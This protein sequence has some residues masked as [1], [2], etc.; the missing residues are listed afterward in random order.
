MGDPRNTEIFL[1]EEGGND[2][3]HHA[4]AAAKWVASTTGLCSL[5]MAGLWMI[6]EMN[7]DLAVQ[8]DL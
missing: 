6:S 4:V 8:K 7:W 3:Q 1:S 5:H 2:V